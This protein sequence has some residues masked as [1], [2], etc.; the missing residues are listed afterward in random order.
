[1]V[2]AIIFDIG[3]VIYDINGIAKEYSILCK[4]VKIVGEA[5]WKDF[6]EEWNKTKINQ[7]SCLGF[8]K[9]IAD[10]LKVSNNEIKSI[11]INNV[12][13]DYDMKKLILKLKE[14]YK[15]EILSNIISDLLIKDLELWNF[16]QI[17]KVVTSCE[18]KVKKP[19]TEAINLIINKLKV[20]KEEVI[21]IDDSKKTIEAYS[22]LGIKC[23]LFENK[24]QLIKELNK[25]GVQ[26]T[27]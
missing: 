12:K 15:I 4:K 7:M 22:K 19:D 16:K 27:V 3:G 6:R 10:K 24:N 25:L 1:M 5:P 26:S 9:I 21:F 13:I 20:K 14:N 23:I 2:K 17:A 11:F 8:Y 18:D